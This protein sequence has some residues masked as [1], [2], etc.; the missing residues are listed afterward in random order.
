MNNLKVTR[1]GIVVSILV[2][3]LISF[4]SANHIITPSSFSDVDEDAIYT[5]IISINNNDTGPDANITQVDITIPTNLIFI[6]GTNGTD[7]NSSTF[8]NTSE[9][10]TW[11]SSIN[12][13]ETNNFQFNGNITT[14]GNYTINITTTNS[15]G[16]SL[17]IINLTINLVVP[18]CTED[19]SYTPWSDCING[20]ETRTAND[21]NNCGTT[22]DRN[23][24]SRTCTVINT[25]SCIQ[26]WSI[27]EWS[28]CTDSLQTRTV[29]DSSSCNNVTGKPSTNQSCT[30]LPSCTPDWD[31]GEGWEPEKCPKNET[32]TRTCTDANSCEVNTGKPSE[33][34]ECTYESSVNWKIIG[35]TA[36][37]L[38]F[39]AIIFAVV[40]IF[41][42]KKT[43]T[44]DDESDEGTYQ[45]DFYTPPT[46]PPPGRIQRNLPLRRP[47]QQPVRQQTN[48]PLRRPVRRPINQQTNIP[49]NT[50]QRRFQQPL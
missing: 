31:C 13:S 43:G 36:G 32:Q 23:T 14:P 11:T 30:I 33:E 21:T 16:I 10:L 41:F 29:T 42:R 34:R 40:I 26:N 37:G 8:S 12:S 7:V 50:I 25:T 49:P 35:I 5:Y 44:L 47:I 19:W 46:S 3:L 24:L 28:T 2:L 18:T 45:G 22:D 39:A 17:S 20:N 38:T 4:I 6:S 9:V 48:V 1:R 27:G 15:S